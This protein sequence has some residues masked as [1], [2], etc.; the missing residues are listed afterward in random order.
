MKHGPEKPA[1]RKSVRAYNGGIILLADKKTPPAI[2]RAG[3]KSVGDN[4]PGGPMSA[5]RLHRVWR[6][7][8]E[9]DHSLVIGT[10]NAG[11]AGRPGSD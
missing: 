8:Y 11:L 7:V 3:L 10:I 6:L 5:A 4:D 1:R 9:I 2:R